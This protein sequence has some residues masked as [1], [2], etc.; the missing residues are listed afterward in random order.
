[1]GETQRQTLK[2]VKEGAMWKVNDVPVAGENR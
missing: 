2:L 1:M